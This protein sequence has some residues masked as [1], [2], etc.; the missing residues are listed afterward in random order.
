V[1]VLHPII[2]VCPQIVG[3]DFYFRNT[4][5][6][7]HGFPL[8]FWHIKYSSYLYRYA[9]EKKLE[10]TV[11]VEKTKKKIRES[12]NRWLLHLI[13]LYQHAS[14]FKLYRFSWLCK[15]LEVLCVEYAPIYPTNWVHR[16]S[17]QMII[18]TAFEVVGR[19]LRKYI[20]N[21]QYLYEI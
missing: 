1:Y 15:L 3:A 8:F 20:I 9:R 4:C 6:A 13:F 19:R 17:N 14:K 5:F 7:F 2:K 10:K 21:V 16:E 12:D 18:Y 11:R